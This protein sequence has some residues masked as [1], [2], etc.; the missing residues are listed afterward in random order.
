MELV[1]TP[2]ERSN[3]AAKRAMWEIANKDRIYGYRRAHAIK[4]CYD[5]NSFPA[6]STF[7]KYRITEEEALHLVR[8]IINNIG[9][10]KS[11]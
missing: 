8:H 4:Q 7:Q 3:P 9:R 10:D 5:R 11:Q 1:H 2:E 6:P